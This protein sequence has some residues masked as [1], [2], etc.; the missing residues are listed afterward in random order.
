LPT[1]DLSLPGG[2]WPEIAAASPGP[3]KSIVVKWSDFL[4]LNNVNTDGVPE[5]AGVYLLWLKLHRNSWRLF[6]VGNSDNL[7][8]TLKRHT[9]I[10]EPDPLIKRKAFNCILGFEYL[11]HP[12]NSNREGMVKFLTEY[13]RPEHSCGTTR[14]DIAALKVNIPKGAVCTP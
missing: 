4:S 9:S 12:D 13:C 8:S 2:H 11:V 1:A 7:R 6:Y 3:Q 10:Q 5:L 14:P